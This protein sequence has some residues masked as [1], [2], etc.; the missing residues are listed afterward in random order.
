LHGLMVRLKRPASVPRSGHRTLLAATAVLMAALFLSSLVSNG[1]H[2]HISTTSAHAR[3]G[4][5]TPLVAN[6]HSALHIARPS[7]AGLRTSTAE[8]VIS[9]PQPALHPQSRS[10]APF[11]PTPT[12]MDASTSTLELPLHPVDLDATASASLSRGFAVITT[13]SLQ[14][15]HHA[16]A[17]R[18]LPLATSQR[19][20]PAPAD[21]TPAQVHLAR[22]A[23]DEAR[24]R[25]RLPSKPPMVEYSWMCVRPFR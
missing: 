11:P 5:S 14:L 1:L 6:V 19:V 18:P 22:R 8:A 9:L 20:R 25:L 7:E 2:I 16:H 23:G 4:T 17:P 21:G 12:S 3:E 15:Q 24:Q 13:E 10:S